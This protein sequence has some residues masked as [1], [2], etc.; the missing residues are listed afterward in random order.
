MKIRI[1]ESVLFKKNNI[2][3]LGVLILAVAAQL[4]ARQSLA[5]DC[6]GMISFWVDANGNC[7]DLSEITQRTSR[8][9][10][11][12]DGIFQKRLTPLQASIVSS[13]IMPPETDIGGDTEFIEGKFGEN[14]IG[15]IS[16]VRDRPGEFCAN[17]KDVKQNVFVRPLNPNTGLPVNPI[18]EKQVGDDDCGIPFLSD[19]EF[20]LGPD[21]SP[22]LV[23]TSEF[24]LKLVQFQGETWNDVIYS[25]SFIPDSENFGI[26]AEPLSTTLSSLQ[27]RA[28]EVVNKEA[29]SYR[30]IWSWISIAPN[31]RVLG[32][33]PI[34]EFP[35]DLQKDGSNNRVSGSL[36]P[37]DGSRFIRIDSKGVFEFSST[38]QDI[39]TIYE[40]NIGELRTWLIPAGEC[41][42]L[43]LN[44][45]GNP[46]ACP[47]IVFDLR[48][49]LL[50][51]IG[52]RVMVQKWT[53]EWVQVLQVPYSTRPRMDATVIQ[54]LDTP[55]SV[56]LATGDR[57]ARL[58]FL[59]GSYFT[60]SDNDVALRSSELLYFSETE[61]LGVYF[62]EINSLT[63]RVKMI[64]INE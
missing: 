39:Q 18:E 64:E 9:T 56:I 8:D 50:G 54:H 6:S 33:V 60:V 4:Y 30:Q 57:D 42:F 31:G 12:L 13:G 19:A 35:G 1:F 28:F 14:L 32:L 15:L 38:G 46:E 59:D 7:T 61:L 2:N 16:Y 23:Y 24:G 55:R 10:S 11:N 40:G 22:I 53:G 49:R 44:N 17:T 3:F 48:N 20:G 29:L 52:F 36:F 58:F 41:A 34:W 47:A 26:A 37:G 5:D 27:L 62:K 51:P 45:P 43:E 63:H 25:N 21:N